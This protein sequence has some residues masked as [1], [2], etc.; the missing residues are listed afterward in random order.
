MFHMKLQSVWSDPT[1]P[2]LE[3][4][5][6]LYVSVCVC[7]WE[8][9]SSHWPRCFPPA[10]LYLCGGYVSHCW[11][12]NSLSSASTCMYI[13]V[14]VSC[15]SHCQFLHKN[16]LHASCRI[17]S[18]RAAS[19]RAESSSVRKVKFVVRV[20]NFNW[21][22]HDT[23]QWNDNNN[24]NKSI[25]TAC[26]RWQDT[27]TLWQRRPDWLTGWLACPGDK[28]VETIIQIWLTVLAITFD[29]FV[30]SCCCCSCLLENRVRN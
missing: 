11:L 25:T 27:T 1:R 10:S 20:T 17:V 12:Y 3:Q 26:W 15:W 14:C 8:M 23:K 9:T 6:E 2:R 5:Q 24:N 21:Y 30:C 13:C 29:K 19:R 7:V 16:L 22:S 28:V 4:T 18:Y